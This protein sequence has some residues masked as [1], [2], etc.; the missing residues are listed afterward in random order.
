MDRLAGKN[1]LIII[2]KDYYM[3]SELEPVI[4]SMK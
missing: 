2:P 1:I 3:E 4:E